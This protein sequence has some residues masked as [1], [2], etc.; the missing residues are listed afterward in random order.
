[1]PAT[2]P[3]NNSP[4]VQFSRVS[5]TFT[6]VRAVDNISFD[7]YRGEFFSM[8]GPSGCGKTTTLGLLAG[9]EEEVRSS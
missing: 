9:F 6:D 3:Q 1:M 8:L 5:K 2:V 7:I 4:V